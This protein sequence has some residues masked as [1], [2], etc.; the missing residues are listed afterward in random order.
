MDGFLL[1]DKPGG[2]TSHDVVDRV[3]RLLGIRRVGH[4]GTLDPLATGLLIVMVG[5]ATR[6]A[7]SLLDSDKTYVATLCLGATTDTQ[8]A[9]GRVIERRPVE[10]LREEE[11]RRA[12]EKF[13]GPITQQ[14]PSFSAVR[15]SG[16]R[17]YEL[18][19]A[20][21]EIP[22]RF[23]NVDIRELEI[24]RFDPPEVEF[25]VTCSKGTYIRTLCADIGRELGCGGFLKE[26]RRTRIGTISVDQ[27]V[28]LDRLE[29]GRILSVLP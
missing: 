1:I 16:K 25:R 18:A 23:R 10:G 13:R 19:R 9:Q 6:K 8:D 14:V 15:I 22:P 3:R 20:G 5:Q 2:M 26:L 11:I 24:L 28:R 12:F 4:G 29:P 17:A 21:K 27:A 7:A